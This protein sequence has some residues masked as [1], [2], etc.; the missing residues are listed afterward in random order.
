MTKWALS[1]NH[2]AGSHLETSS[3]VVVP[4]VSRVDDRS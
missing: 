3:R 2:L 1:G 4:S